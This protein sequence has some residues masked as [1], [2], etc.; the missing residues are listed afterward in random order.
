MVNV[1]LPLTFAWSKISSQPELGRKAIT[2]Y[3]HH[4]R[5]ASN[6]LERHM[7][8]QLGRSG[9]R[10]NSA[11]QQQGLIHLYHTRCIQGK[12][13]GCPLSQPE[14][15]NHVEIQTG[16]FTGAE[17]VVTAGGNHSGIIGT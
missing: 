14:P 3:R 10:V 8:E 17:P 1:V 11:G 4:P 6:T 15:G 7:R 5:L 12:C 2:L 13:Y 16:S 9:F